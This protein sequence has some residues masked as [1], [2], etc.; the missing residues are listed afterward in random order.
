MLKEQ[1]LDSMEEIKKWEVNIFDFPQTVN[2]EGIHDDYEGFRII[3]RGGNPS[4]V[5]KLSFENYLG[6]RNFD[7]SYRLKS[8]NMFPNNSREWCLFISKDSD[9]INWAVIESEGFQTKEKIIHFYIATPN[10]IVEVLSFE[11]P[12]IEEL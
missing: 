1:N 12:E 3:L 8:L 4:R 10:D 2:V 5:Y 6:Y 7:E 11:E 9:F